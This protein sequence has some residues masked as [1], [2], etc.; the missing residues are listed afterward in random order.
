MITCTIVYEII[1]S[2]PEHML[3]EPIGEKL[4][5]K[6]IPIVHINKLK[7]QDQ[8]LR[9]LSKRVFTYIDN[10]VPMIMQTNCEP[11]LEAILK[12]LDSN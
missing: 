10:L 12:N 4:L 6:V 3:K 5:A 9:Q 7:T 2:L 8:K 1:K 11:I